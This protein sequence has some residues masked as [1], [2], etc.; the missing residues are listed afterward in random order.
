M[1][2]A[3][4]ILATHRPALGLPAGRQERAAAD[5]D[6]GHRAQ[7]RAADEARPTAVATMLALARFGADPLKFL[8]SL[9]D[10]GREIVPFSLGN[11]HCH[12]LTQARARQAG[13]RE[14]GVAAALAR[15]HDGARSLVRRR[16]DPHR[17]RRAPPPAR[18]A[19]EAGPRRP[20]G[21]RRHRRGPRRAARGLL[22]GGRADRAL[23]RAAL[24]VLGDRVGEPDRRGPR[25]LARAAEGPG[26]GHRRRCSGCWGRSARRAGARRS[27][28]ARGLAPLANGSTPPSTP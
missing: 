4:L 25:R 6:V 27:R 2:E 18:R 17:G 16:A 19:V 23:H 11:L 14:R 1:K 28:P 26:G 12:L 9:R 15:A 10:D 21:G 3:V 24:A 5:G 13:A 22:D 7:A 8:D 20:D